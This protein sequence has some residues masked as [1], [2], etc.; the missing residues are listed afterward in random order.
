MY[1]ENNLKIH[2]REKFEPRGSP[3]NIVGHALQAVGKHRKHLL[4]IFI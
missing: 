3:Q 2:I 4:S 1:W